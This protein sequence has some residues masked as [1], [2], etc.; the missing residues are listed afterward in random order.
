[1]W[2]YAAAVVSHAVDFGIDHDEVGVGR[3]VEVGL[4]DVSEGRGPLLLGS[5]ASMYELGGSSMRYR[6][7]LFGYRRRRVPSV[8][9]S[10]VY[11]PRQEWGGMRV[12]VYHSKPYV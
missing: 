1:M 4:V 6:E 11:T 3:V 8:Q 9:R 5:L 10:P 7:S 12:F 2:G